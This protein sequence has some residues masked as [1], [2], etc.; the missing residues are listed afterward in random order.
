MRTRRLAIA[1]TTLAACSGFGT[2]AAQLEPRIVNG[3]NTADYPAVGVLLGSSNFDTASL[4]CTG[5]LIG[6]ETFLTAGHC[7]EGDLDPTHY[8]VFLQH[9]GFFTVASVALHPDYGFPVA[10]LA[11]LKLAVP[12]TGFGGMPLNTTVDPVPDTTGTIVG[13]GRTGGSNYDYGVK[14]HGKV[15]TTACSGDIS[16][17]TSVCWD[18]LSPLGDPGDNSNT[19]NGDSGGP[20]FIDFGAGLTLA[21]V[22]SGGSG[23]NCLPVDNSFDADVYYYAAWI[24]GEA[25]A[26]LG[27]SVCGATPQIGDA[28]TS[29]Y[30]GDGTLSSGNPQGVHAFTVPAGTVELR[31]TMNG[32]E[33]GSN[34]FD[35]YVKA[36]SAPTTLNFDCKADGINQYGACAFANP[37]PGTWYAMI[38]RYAGSGEYQVTAV[39]FGVDCTNPGS[40]GLPCSDGNQC[41]GPDACLGGA[42][43]GAA[44]GDGAACEDG[45]L[46][47]QGDTCLSGSCTSGAAPAT[48]CT[49]PFTPGLSFLYLKDHPTDDGRDKLVWRWRQGSATDI[50]DFGNPL[51]DTDYALCVYDANGGTPELTI[52]RI[53]SGG[54]NWIALANGYRYK[55][56]K[57]ARDGIGRIRLAAG[58]D[59]TAYIR[60]KG[61]G[62]NLEM[63][64]LPL[65]QQ[66]TVR[67]QLLNDLGKCWEA[68]YSTSVVNDDERFKALAD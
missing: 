57:R 43:V 50:A 26:D 38:N 67:V 23:A 48:A 8:G 19:C 15:V 3:L 12:V 53:I 66:G 34:D 18:F 7:V 45:D 62:P 46:C 20:L 63:I 60:V 21:G 37:A 47:T 40:D 2:A 52:R 17:T 11:V 24:A 51:V 28:E 61:K 16:D 30:A 55:D 10:D 1:L 9:A 31:V 56:R 25:G 4:R 54:S 58:L 36:G 5:T 65:L 22:T 49:D 29:V 6:C 32:S 13:F 14:R 33:A 44:L 35:L 39:S 64:G 68:E 27:A 59:G 41:T 42:C